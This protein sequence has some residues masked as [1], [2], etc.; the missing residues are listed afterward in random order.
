MGLVPHRQKIEHFVI[1]S[2]QSEKDR[3]Q[4]GG[5]L[6]LFG[7][8]PLL[9]GNPLTKGATWPLLGCSPLRGQ[10]E[11]KI[12]GVHIPPSHDPSK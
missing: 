5:K 1:Q 11:N 4:I 3:G 2:K 7:Q 10:S 12:R 8:N 6:L 9:G